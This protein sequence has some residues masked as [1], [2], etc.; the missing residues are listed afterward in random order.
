[1]IL[2][3]TI[4]SFLRDDDYRDL[5][6]TTLV[7]LGIGTIAYHFLEGWT[8]IDSIYFSVIT[9]TTIGYGDFSPET[10]WGK[11]FTIFYI[12]IGIGIILSFIS[13]V[14]NHYYDVKADLRK[15]A[16]SDYP[17]KNERDRLI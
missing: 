17:R 6:M 2:F 9:L 15:K 5:L 3:K 11:I 7:V 16:D 13:T 1:M 10:T 14:Y 8:W 4:V 12:V